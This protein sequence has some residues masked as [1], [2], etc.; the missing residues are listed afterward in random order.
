MSSQNTSQVTIS[1]SVA[2]L[3][4]GNNMERSIHGK[5]SDTQTMLNFDTLI[6]RLLDNR[7]LNRLIYF[8]EGRNI[9]EKLQERLYVNYHGSVRPCHKSADI[10]LTI[11]AMQLASKVDS[12]I[13]MSGDSDF[14]E[15]VRHLKSE[16]V[17]VEIAAIASTASRFLLEEA[18]YFHEITEADWFTL[19]Q[20]KVSRN[21]RKRKQPAGDA[22]VTPTP[23]P[24]SPAPE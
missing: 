2:I 10:P 8:R 19:P 23:D 3:V 6:P 11:N 16:G 4:D 1:Q 14:V 15:L 13:I 21:K 18:D 24:S 7:G 12:I 22:K 17:R 9:S 20:K 5:T